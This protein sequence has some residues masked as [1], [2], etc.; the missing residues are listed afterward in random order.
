MEE[1]ELQFPGTR[2]EERAEEFKREFFVHNESCIN[3][4]ALLDQMPYREWLSNTVRNSHAETVRK[5]WVVA[6]T[7]F[8]V[9]KRDDRIVGM[10]DIRHSL[11]NAFLSQYGG[12]IGYA[13][14]P[15]ERRKGYAT[16]MLHMALSYA[17]SL[18]LRKVMLGCYANNVASIKTIEKCGGILVFHEV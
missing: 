12:H 13:V 5:D 1:N 9:R 14:R 17:K 6:T 16:G 4:S 2:H 7:F 11:D 10:I 18:G 8:A 3:S 15:S